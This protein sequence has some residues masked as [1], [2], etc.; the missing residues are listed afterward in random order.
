MLR[1]K[2]LLLCCLLF[3]LP[4]IT[5]AAQEPFWPGVA[6]DPAVPTIKAVLGHDHGEKIT[7]PQQVLKY[8]DALSAAAPERTRLV[9]YATSW[10]GRPLK[11]LVISSLD[12][13][14][15]LE[16]NQDRMQKLVDPRLGDDESQQQLLRQT[17]PVSW[18]SYGVHGDE[19]SSTDA[20]LLAMYH[21][22]AAQG[23]E[24]V[25][26][27][28]TESIVVLD[29]SQNPDGRARFVQHFE[30]NLGLQPA[31]H[32]LAAEH[33]QGWPGGRTNHYLFDM[34]RDWFAL[35]QPETRGRIKHFQKFFP[36]VHA[37]VHEMEV[38]SSYYF[39]PPAEPYNPFISDRQLSNLN[40]YGKGNAAAFDQFDF[41]YFTRE[42]FDAHY[43]GYG[44]TW[45]AFHGSIGMTFEMASA[46]GLVQRK[47]N[48][49]LLSYKDG[50]H[51]HFV[52]S[53]S[54]MQTTATNAQKLLK[55]LVEYRSNALSDERLYI[56]SEG[57]RS[58]QRKL[59]N[60]LTA[61]GIE[62][63]R[64][65]ST[66]RACGKSHS[67]GSYVVNAGQP[68]GW[69]VRTLLDADSPIDK[70]FWQEKEKNRAQ[71]IAVDLYD[72]LAWSMPGL[73]GLEPTICQRKLEGLVLY[74]PKTP[75]HQRPTE[76]KFAYVIPN[77][78]SA[79][80]QFL[81]AGLRQ[82]MPILNV[83]AEF[84]LPGRD[85]A[86]GTLVIKVA[87]LEEGMLHQLSQL[88]Q[89]F[90]VELVPTDSSWT[91][92][93]ANFGS[94]QVTQLKA[95]Q[96][97]LV[98]DEPT[99]ANAAGNTRFVIERQ[100]GYPVTTIRTPYLASRDLSYFDVLFIPEGGDYAGELGESGRKNLTAWV[101]NGGVL[102]TA[103]SATQ[104][105]LENGLGLLSTKL[106]ANQDA[107]LQD[108]GKTEL[109]VA[110]II[111]TEDEYLKI[112]S[113]GAIKPDYVPGV[114]VRGRVD[115]EH[116]LAAGVADTVNLVLNGSDIYTPLK[117]G[118]GI[119]VVRYAAS[120]E[121]LQG[122][123]LWEQNRSQLAYK[124][125]VMARSV[126][127]GEVIAFTTDPAFRG[128][129]DGLH[130]MLGNAIFKAPSR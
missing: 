109:A 8:L 27:I 30:Q 87:S 24:T 65:Q 64:L 81:A 74:D 54:T 119:N 99:Y 86:R 69:L 123:Y 102:I 47:D 90:D 98:W 52:S 116:W 22:L 51:R 63:H 73:Y 92:A 115:H 121:L 94:P 48:G 95:P 113:K 3:V 25:E 50:V 17:K 13:M 12:N 80:M 83:D 128:Y 72:V 39:P 42:I 97:A 9:H 101:D 125:A 126:G 1:N 105:L 36:V 120:E 59:A 46:R 78:T 43:A 62:V 19:I 79:S 71:G 32:Q 77:N 107:S 122:G 96:I 6:Y 84:T 130:V 29:P 35:T 129:L 57:D 114:I 7:T 60:K 103:G 34:N 104:L 45:P 33:Q 23:D 10:E 53:M 76:A 15:Q 31:I 58:L 68:A 21:L 40:L 66:T 70:A 56:F 67:A 82:G 5:S 2:L 14:S 28:L 26:R 16:A 118:N 85:F 112:V 55:D 110:S 4:L 93:G 108:G 41:D 106:E 20:A 124:P 127:A 11:Y 88:A 117:H 91:T 61:Q 89:Q 75:T 38:D 44:D 111:D 18:L 37:D 49:E 100:I